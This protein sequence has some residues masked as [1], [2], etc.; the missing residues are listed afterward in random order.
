LIP[1]LLVCQIVEKKRSALSFRAW[2][3]ESKLDI[4]PYVSFLVLVFMSSRLLPEGGGSQIPHL[5]SVSAGQISSNIIYYL[6]LPAGFFGRGY[7]PAAIYILTFPFMVYGII[8]GLK[9]DYAYVV[10]ALCTMG[11]YVLWPERQ[12]IRFI[13]SVLP[14]YIY[15][16]YLGLL[17]VPGP[18]RSIAKE[19]TREPGIKRNIL[20]FSTSLFIAIYLLVQTLASAYPN[21]KGRMVLDGPFTP[22]SIEMFNYILRTTDKNDTVVFFKPRAMTLITGRR[23]FASTDPSQVMAAKGA[24]LVIH[25]RAD[26]YLQLYPPGD[27]FQKFQDVFEPG[28]ENRDFL[29][30]R[31]RE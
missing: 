31:I 18:P 15:F 3:R 22:T 28:F 9:R 6:K 25:K 24:Y 29:I 10:Y 8:K 17:S 12:G 19:S 7:L 20:F 1:A 14:F 16:S 30:Y 5:L 27:L 26:S 21:I 11:I 23:S 2:L 13:F 4:L